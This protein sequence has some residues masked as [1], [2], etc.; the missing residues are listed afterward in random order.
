MTDH[1]DK[2]RLEALAAGQVSLIFNSDP[3]DEQPGH[4]IP[5][6]LLLCTTTS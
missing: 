3:G 1:P 5:K 4:S 6:K 2:L